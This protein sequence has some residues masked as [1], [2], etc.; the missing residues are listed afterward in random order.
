MVQI[1]LPDADV[2][3][4]AH[5][6]S[7]HVT[8]GILGDDGIGFSLHDA[9]SLVGCKIGG[10]FVAVYLQCAIDGDAMWNAIILHQ[11]WIG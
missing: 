5:E 11:R 8:F 9:L 3:I 7:D 6:L 2:G 1:Q 4:V 10:V